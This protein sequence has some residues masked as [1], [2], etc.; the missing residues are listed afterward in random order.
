MQDPLPD[1]SEATRSDTENIHRL[2]LKCFE[3]TVNMDFN[4]T[5][6]QFAQNV[7]KTL[8][9]VED[10]DDFDETE[11]DEG[12]FFSYLFNKVLIRTITKN[13]CVTFVGNV[14][15]IARGLIDY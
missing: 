5:S 1:S 13:R 7:L 14:E 9:A 8:H 11:W 6:L 15:G 4:L 12:D 2:Y 10:M 3:A